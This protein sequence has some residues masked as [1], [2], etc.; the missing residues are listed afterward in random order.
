MFN[1]FRRNPEK[2]LQQRYEKKLEEAMKA[3]RNGKIYE[4]STLT[5]EAE[6]IR[7][8]INK[9]NNTPSTFS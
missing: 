2:K 8:Q 7:E 5:A 3:Q 4:Y 1:I 6:A 9:M